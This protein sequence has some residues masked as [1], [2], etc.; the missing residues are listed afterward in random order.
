M[1]SYS[2]PNDWQSIETAIKKRKRIVYAV[3]AALTFLVIGLSH[4]T[5]SEQLQ[6]LNPSDTG[7]TLYLKSAGDNITQV[8]QSAL[9]SLAMLAFISLVMERSL[10]VFVHTIASPRKLMLQAEQKRL[11]P[12]D[13]ASNSDNRQQLERVNTAIQ[14]YKITT[15]MMTLLGALTIGIFLGISGVRIFEPLFSLESVHAMPGFQQIMFRILDI[16]LT[17]LAIAGGSNG[18]HLIS[19]RIGSYIDP[20]IESPAPSSPSSSQPVSS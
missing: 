3:M 15:K 19:K 16:T 10:E 9:D 5:S 8:L 4:T 14:Q 17:G 7:S 1:T 13:R 12:D 20:E 6:L 11:Q 18:I 2:S